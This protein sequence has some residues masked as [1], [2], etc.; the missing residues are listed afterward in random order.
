VNGVSKCCVG[1]SLSLSMDDYDLNTS[2]WSAP[3]PLERRAFCSTLMSKIR[4]CST[5]E[6]I[7]EQVR[8]MVECMRFFVESFR[9]VTHMFSRSECKKLISS[10]RKCLRENLQRIKTDNPWR[11]ELEVYASLLGAIKPEAQAQAEG[12]VPL[13]LLMSSVLLE[14]DDDDDDDDDESVSLGRV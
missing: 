1:L 8:L 2:S 5:A 9:P 13:R 11:L 7:D 10:A 6:E 4:M 3:A 14:V 12:K